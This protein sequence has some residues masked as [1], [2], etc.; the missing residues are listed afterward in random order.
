MSTHRNG[1]GRLSGQAHQPEITAGPGRATEG[2]GAWDLNGMAERIGEALRRQPVD[3]GAE[4]AALAAFRSAR[5]ASDA[6]LRTRRQ[7][8]WRPRTRKQRWTRGGALAL[9]ASTLLGG[10][11]FASIGVVHRGQHPAHEAGTSHSTRRPA[12]PA[13][14]EQGS[15]STGSGTAPTSAPSRPGTAQNVEAQCRAY[16]KVKGRGHALKAAAW[17]SLV[18]AAGGEQ[19]VAAY[20]VQL[21]GTA[22]EVDPTPTKPNNTGKSGKGQGKPSVVG[23]VVE[24]VVPPALGGTRSGAGL[25]IID[26]PGPATPQGVLAPPG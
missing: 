18:R 8:D 10:I 6:A 15:A 17:H 23:Q 13:P 20:C 12:T 22:N 14:G 25:R 5:T 3:D 19:Q 26:G 1:D 7:D 4:Q 24:G 16:G 21:T 2:D 11:A 9:A